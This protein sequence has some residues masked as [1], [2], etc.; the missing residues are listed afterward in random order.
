MPH[1]PVKMAVNL[2][3]HRAVPMTHQLGDGQVVVPLDEFPR[4]EPVPAIVC[5]EPLSWS[6]PGKVDTGLTVIRIA[7]TPPG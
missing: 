3:Q 6:S 7:R 4:G 5:G 1:V 2:R